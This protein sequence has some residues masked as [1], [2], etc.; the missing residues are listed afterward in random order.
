MSKS[1][2]EKS[3]TYTLHVFLPESNCMKK[4][5]HMYYMNITYKPLFGRGLK[6]QILF[7]LVLCPYKNGIFVW[8][9]L[10]EVDNKG[11]TPTHYYRGADWSLHAIWK[12]LKFDTFSTTEA[13]GND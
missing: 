6:G 13:K 11:A 12:F 1:E 9:A 4:W 7:H 2:K 5:T 3:Y 8:K 10:K